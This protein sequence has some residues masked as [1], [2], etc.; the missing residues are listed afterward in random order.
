MSAKKKI[1][2]VAVCFLVALG[3]LSL[4]APKLLPAR[5]GS[6]PRMVKQLQ[7]L[8]FK[9]ELSL[10][11][12][13]TLF[14]QFKRYREELNKGIL[15]IEQEGPRVEA[16]LYWPLVNIGN[17]YRDAGDYAR[18]ETSWLL[19]HR[20]QPGAFVPLGNL[21]ELYFRYVKDYQKAEEYYLK[22]VQIKSDYLDTF[23]YELYQ[24]YRFFMKDE[25]RAEEVLIQGIKQYPEET[26]ILAQLA[27]HYRQ[28]GQIEKAISRYN[29][30]LVK[31]PDSAVAK[32]ALTELTGK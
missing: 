30:L 13:Q 24:L 19:A 9:K 18:A 23:Y 12:E 5:E 20:I 27:L 14:E 22:A 7:T 17:V 26:N 8:A 2:I 28:T 11:Q 3:V 29:E 16:I 15:A 25:A 32:R 31:K 10:E 4:I 1:I 6:L 21:G